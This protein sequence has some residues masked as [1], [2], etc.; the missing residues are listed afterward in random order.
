MNA[1]DPRVHMLSP[2]RGLRKRNA[3]IRSKNSDLLIFCSIC[4]CLAF[5]TIFQ[6]L[7]DGIS[8]DLSWIEEWSLLPET[9]SSRIT[10]SKQ[11]LLDA[12]ARKV[13]YEAR[14]V[15]EENDW[16]FRHRT[17]IRILFV[18]VGKAGGA[19][20]NDVL[21]VLMQAPKFLKCRMHRSHSSRALLRDSCRDSSKGV[22]HV[23]WLTHR[24]HADMHLERPIDPEQRDWLLNNAN[25]D[26][27]TI[28]DPV[29][30]LVSA[31]NYHRWLVLQRGMEEKGWE[32]EDS[33]MQFFRCF[34]SSQEL[35]DTID[36]RSDPLA[37]LGSDFA[38]CKILGTGV[39]NGSLAVPALKHFEY[40][41]RN[42]LNRTKS[43][44]IKR[45]TSFLASLSRLI[46]GNAETRNTMTK[47]NATIAVV[48]T[49][50]LWADTA[51]LE[52]MLGG[53]PARFID[54]QQRNYR[55]SHGSEEYAVKS[56]VDEEGAKAMCCVI[57][58]DLQAYQEIV[59]SAINLKE[60][61]KMQ[62]LLAA[63]NRCGT[64]D[65]RALPWEKLSAW[66]WKKWALSS[67]CQP[68]QH[69]SLDSE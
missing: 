54:M 69:N 30:R 10:A 2:K 59:L 7:P 18:H 63:H 40:N 57:W 9:F 22:K 36:P 13:M 55:V 29:D 52:A 67:E 56:S 51:R 33:T 17:E 39:V 12:A 15:M 37:H 45:E 1:V 60:S 6:I 28:R 23:S 41:F 19:S 64:N 31:Y 61:E 25:L 11:A 66:Q 47:R 21:R 26:L 62:T 20:L 14:Q 8:R 53:S 4:L 58:D 48:R 68:T 43:L 46:L 24:I 16:P 3:V 50:N 27:F 44:P 65:G 32:Y 35:A 38:D 49:E 5:Q 34:D 42:Y